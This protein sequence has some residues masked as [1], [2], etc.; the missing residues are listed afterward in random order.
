MKILQFI[1]LLK[2]LINAISGKG[3]IV[4]LFLASNVYG[5][6]SMFFMPKDNKTSSENFVPEPNLIAH[7]DFGDTRSYFPGST[8][9]YD[10]G[11]YNYNAEISENTIYNSEDGGGSIDLYSSN[12]YLQQTPTQS[13]IKTIILWIRTITDTNPIYIKI[14]LYNGGYNQFQLL[15]GKLDASPGFNYYSVNSNGTISNAYEFDFV[16][17]T[18]S[19][20]NL[21][22]TYNETTQLFE[23]Y[24]NGQ[25]ANGTITNVGS[26]VSTPYDNIQF[27]YTNVQGYPSYKTMVSEIKLKSVKLT[28]QEVLDYYNSTKDEKI[29]VP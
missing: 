6:N 22:V 19:W 29:Y 28:A 4:L 20:T 14:G 5:Q 8:T 15:N 12:L 24:I 27:D 23:T 26:N 16:F 18:T 25:L 10:L 1:E 13:E 11:P 9:L 17:P 21:I 2:K 7:Y 3:G